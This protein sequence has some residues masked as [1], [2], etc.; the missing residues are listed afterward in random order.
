MRSVDPQPTVRVC[1]FRPHHSTTRLLL[2]ISF[3]HPCSS[4]LVALNTIHMPRPFLGDRLIYL[5]HKGSAS[6]PRDAQPD[7]LSRLFAPNPARATSSFPHLGIFTPPALAHVICNLTFKITR[8]P[9]YLLL[10]PSHYVGFPGSCL[11]AT[12]IPALP[13]ET[14]KDL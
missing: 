10:A 7:F 9:V 6:K 2:V 12:Q 11:S 8:R 4:K 3:T 13:A 5:P 1:E 14:C